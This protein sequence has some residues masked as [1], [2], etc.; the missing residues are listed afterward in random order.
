LAFSG[1]REFRD[2]SACRP[3]AAASAGA[4]ASL[5][6]ESWRQGSVGAGERSGAARGS[7]LDPRTSAAARSRR[8]PAGAPPTK[9]RRVAPSARRWRASAPTGPRT[10]PAGQP[11]S[12]RRRRAPRGRRRPDQRTRAPTEFRPT[13]PDLSFLTGPWRWAAPSESVE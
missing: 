3:Q 1:A 2:S 13:E 9:R 6:S 8:R 12:Y 4:G 10:R 11:F 7:R 5:S